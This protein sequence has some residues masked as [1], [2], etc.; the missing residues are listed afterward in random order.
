MQPWQKALI[1]YLSMFSNELKIIPIQKPVEENSLYTSITMKRWFRLCLTGNVTDKKTISP[2][3]YHKEKRVVSKFCSIM[4][5]EALC[6]WK[7][8]LEWLSNN[9]QFQI[10]L[11]SSEDLSKH[12][13]FQCQSTWAATFLLEHCEG[14]WTMLSLRYPS[15]G[16]FRTGWI[17]Q[18]SRGKWYCQIE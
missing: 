9:G 18:H 6:N 3:C 2:F 13:S 12:S 4:F 15:L 11:R 14:N 17:Y 5:F 16:T 10:I 8:S 1:I 7:F